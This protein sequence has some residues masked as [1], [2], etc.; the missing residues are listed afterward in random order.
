M[1]NIVQRENVSRSQGKKIKK[2]KKETLLS[3]YY[4][5][6]A[7]RILELQK[8]NKITPTLKQPWNKGKCMT[9]QNVL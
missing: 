2:K 5:T 4:G 8:E 9:N 3:M 1:K 7:V 6:D